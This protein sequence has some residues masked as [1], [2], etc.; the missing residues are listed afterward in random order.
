M[1][2]VRC[3]K[4]PYF[5]P[6]P[7]QG[8]DL[9]NIPANYPVSPN[10]PDF[11]QAEKWPIDVTN[12]IAIALG[13]A[14]VVRVLPGATTSI[15]A[16]P[17]GGVPGFQVNGTSSAAG[18]PLVSGNPN[19]S[20]SFQNSSG[21]FGPNGGLG[22]FG[23]NGASQ[24]AGA[25]PAPPA[26]GTTASSATVDTIYDPA[27]AAASVESAAGA[28]DVLLA[29]SMFWDRIEN[30]PGTMFN[31]F[32]NTRPRLDNAYWRS[33][34]TKL[35]S[36]GAQ[37]G[38]S[39]NSDYFFTP[40]NTGLPPP[41]VNP[42]NQSHLEFGLVQP[43]LKG[44]G[45]DVTRAALVIANTQSNQSAWEFKRRM[46]EMVRSIETAY[47]QLYA[48]QL[49]LK[50][51]DDSMPLYEEVVRIQEDRVRAGAAISA[52]L[53]QVR[54]S[55]LLLRGQRLQA[56]S[57][58][59]LK[60]YTL[61]N[62]MGLPPADKRRMVLVDQPARAPLVV[63]PEFTLTVALDRRPD[64]IRQRLAVK[65]SETQLIVAKNGLLP[66][67][68]GEALYRINGLGST[69]TQSVDQVGENQ[70]QDWRL[71]ASLQYP[72]GNHAARGQFRA[73]QMGVMRE[74]AV[75]KQTTH[76]AAHQI[77]DV[78]RNL[79]WIYQQ[80]EVAAQREVA[81]REWREGARSRFL[82]PVGGVN[83]LQ[84]FQVYLLAIGN[85]IVNQQSEVN[86]LAQYNTALAQLEEVRGTLLNDRGIFIRD[87][88]CTTI[89][90]TT[91]EPR[92][93]ELQHTFSDPRPRGSAAPEIVPPPE[94]NGP[95]PSSGTA[96]AAPKPSAPN[97]SEPKPLLPPPTGT[98]ASAA[99]PLPVDPAA[100]PI[101]VL[102]NQTP[103]APPQPP[104]AI[105]P[106]S[107]QQPVP[108][109]YQE[110]LQPSNP[111]PNPYREALTNPGFG[112]SPPPRLSS[113]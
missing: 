24:V 60:E 113:P 45:P 13:N 82:T 2:E 11:A 30:P 47:W 41:A 55:L 18:N 94:P 32:I 92:E 36:S 72:I 37:A 57:D 111:Y 27:I 23:P 101:A 8:V 105:V 112:P 63:D 44:F 84:A 34:L 54:S 89:Q 19:L 20:N 53:A 39:F 69:L 83:L 74:R 100:R 4:G 87:D 67:L 1:S 7:S 102:G 64:I 22:G 103:W 98:S 12:T 106:A 70:Y 91:Y 95:N 109:R 16:S 15:P 6:L 51:I 88:P 110:A 40:P 14:E 25:P 17:T 26:A 76:I 99:R 71:G 93:P 90:Q 97:P 46:I 43:L 29:T 77:A 33:S 61:R 81:N 107:S 62:L 80:Y 42:Q 56:I 28:F 49:N 50:I 73:A 31:G 58:I 35:Y 108:A 68:N 104:G 10:L 65:I 38:L 66:Q 9:T 59:A 52:D 79:N 48:A 96:P 21:G 75:L 85:S 86:L 5:T 78:L 3:P